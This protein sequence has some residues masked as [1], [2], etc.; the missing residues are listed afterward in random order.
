MDVESTL[1]L[2]FLLLLFVISTIPQVIDLDLLRRLLD[3]CLLRTS[4]CPN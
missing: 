3:I 1:R 2:A 4:T